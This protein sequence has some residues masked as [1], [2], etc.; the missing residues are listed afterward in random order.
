MSAQKIKIIARVRPKL[1]GELDDDGLKIVN[2]TDNTGDSSTST[3][4]GSFVTVTNPR[5]PTQIFK[6]PFVL[7]FFVPLFIYKRFRRFS[8][9][10]DHGSTQ[11]EIYQDV[12]PLLDIVYSGIV[13]F[14]LSTVLPDDFSTP[15]LDGYDI[16]LW[17]YLLWQDL[18]DARN[19]G[20]A[21]SNSSG[22]EGE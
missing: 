5:D 2:G 9:C 10:Y 4:G 8:S 15:F 17:R 12:E 1:Q 19:E 7:C 18:H 11:E 22:S 14:M 16:R 3:T 13:C 6:F 20:G 21:W